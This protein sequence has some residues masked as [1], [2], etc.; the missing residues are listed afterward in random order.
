MTSKLDKIFD[1]VVANPIF[2][3]KY[4]LQ[5]NYNPDEIPHRDQQIDQVASI[6][7][8]SLRLER[9]SNLFVYGQTG[10]G[11]TLC[12]QFVTKKMLERAKEQNLPLKIE[13][14]NCKMKK[15]SD[16]E[17]RILAEIIKKLGYEVPAT[18]LPTQQVY[19][20]FTEIIDREKQLVILVLDEIDQAVKKIN[21]DFLY[22][23]TRLNSELVK[24][25]LCI[26]GISNDLQFLDNIDTRVRSSLSEE[27]LVF[28][29]YNAPQLQEILKKR[30]ETAFNSDVLD[31]GV[32]SKCAAYAARDH[33]DAR[34][35]L[36]LLR[37]AG[38][39]SE[40]SG[41]KKVSME[42]VDEAREKLERDKIVDIVEAAPKQFQLVLLSILKLVE[43]KNIENI[44]TGDVYNLYYELCKKVKIEI[45]TQRRI[46]DIIAEFD[47]LGLINARVIS[48]GRH[49]RTREIK[50]AITDK[51]IPKI[52][53]IL[54]ES[55]NL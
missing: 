51:I 13:Y 30:A 7:A 32:L 50:L 37:I 42:N 45:L 49:G 34:R 26:I 29:P 1:A 28:H 35:A 22:N 5:N 40:R 18:G 8:P 43:Q 44:F 24:G 10:T 6:L 19:S 11:K 12:V 36:D 15:V 41:S 46:S 33:G 38:E 54:S 25:Q 16:T 52:K 21:G 17:Y 39:I 2:K 47:M 23:L 4:V 9:P 48:K 31:E 14:L 3:N 20:K 53:I 55:L 27:E